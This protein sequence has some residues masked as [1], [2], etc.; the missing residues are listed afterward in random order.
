MSIRTAASAFVAVSDEYQ[1]RLIASNF[2]REP[3]ALALY[4]SQAR[5]RGALAIAA[6]LRLEEE[7]EEEGVRALLQTTADKHWRMLH[8]QIVSGVTPPRALDQVLVWLCRDALQQPQSHR[9]SSFPHNNYDFSAAVR[10]ASRLQQQQ[11]QF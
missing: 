8:N 7:D 5:R 11:Q 3:S 4:Q 1:R 6:A 10:G 2:Q 9:F